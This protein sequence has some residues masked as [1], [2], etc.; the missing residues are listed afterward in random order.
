MDEIVPIYNLRRYQSTLEARGPTAV[1]SGIVTKISR[2]EKMPNRARYK[3]QSGPYP[4]TSPSKP[5]GS[6]IA[7]ME[8]R[9]E[10]KHVF[11]LL[12]I[13]PH[14]RAFPW[15][16]PKDITVHEVLSPDEVR[17]DALLILA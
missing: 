1:Q 14:L 15:S 12:D 9:P 3:S 13:V 17:L 6:P 11:D 2:S 5:C 10:L 16:G 8:S 4:T 7:N